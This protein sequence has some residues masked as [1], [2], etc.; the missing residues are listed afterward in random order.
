MS[1]LYEVFEHLQLLGM[2]I[3]M[4]I[5]SVT[6]TDVS[7]DLGELAESL[8]DARVQTIPLRNGWGCRT[9]QTAHHIHVIPIWGVWAPSTVVY[10]HMDAHSL[11]YHRRRFTRFVRVDDV[12]D[13]LT[14]RVKILTE[15]LRSADGYK[16]VVSHIEENFYQIKFFTS[17]TSDSF[18]AITLWL[19]LYNLS[20]CSHIHVI[21]MRCLS[22]FNCCV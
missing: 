7:P 5:H 22:T 21:H 18:S 12:F 9:F 10:R 14:V 1:F 11:W 2:G 17:G 19:K 13:G 8:G 4:H 16:R 15:V 6:T 3:S 20:N